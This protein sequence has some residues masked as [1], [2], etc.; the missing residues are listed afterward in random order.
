MY[1]LPQ[2]PPVSQVSR[3]RVQQMLIE[4]G[5]ERLYKELQSIDPVS[6]GR[7][8]WQ[9][10]YRVSRA[11]EVYFDSGQPVSQFYL[12]KQQLRSRYDF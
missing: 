12:E 10:S 1:G 11:L 6:A 5:K 9:D 8:A 2:T 7:I 3:D 4:L